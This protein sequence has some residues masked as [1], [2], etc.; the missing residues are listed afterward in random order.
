MPESRLEKIRTH[1]KIFLFY[2][3]VFNAALWGGSYILSTAPDD[4]WYDFP[5]FFTA[6]LMGVLGA[7][8]TVNSLLSLCKLAD[9]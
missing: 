1:G 8:G 6:L 3:V 4:A 5:V 2:F 7:V 9:K